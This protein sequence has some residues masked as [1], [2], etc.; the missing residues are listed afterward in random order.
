MKVT[1]FI[2]LMVLGLVLTI[3]ASGCRKHP[4]YM[5]RIPGS[6]TDS[7]PTD[8]PNSPLIKAD[9]TPKANDSGGGIPQGPG[10]DGWIPNPDILQANTVHF[11]FDSSVVKSSEKGNVNAV[12]DYLK[13]NGANALK[14]DGHCD[15]R[16]TEEYNRSLGERRA[17][18]LRENL[19]AL[20]IDPN[21]VDTATFGKDRPVDSGHDESAWK[22]NRRGEFIVLTPPPKAQ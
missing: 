6:R 13:A 5:T 14:I 10:H 11:D 22:K 21:R 3:A 15:E 9:E 19:V 20:G 2:N 8:N 12:A 1:K 7:N 16:G 18:A 17:L 4:G